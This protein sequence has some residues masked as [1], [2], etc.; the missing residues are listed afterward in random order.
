MTTSINANAVIIIN[1]HHFKASEA[2]MWNLT[3]I[4]KVLKLKRGKSPSEWRTKEAKRFSECP[5]KMRSLGQ[6]VT[7]RILADKQVTL[8]YAGWV[9]PEFEDMVYAAFEAILAI[10][11]V[12][13]VV[14]NKMV[15]LSHKAE[16]E[17][18]ERHTN[19]DRDY[20][21]AQLK[22]LRGSVRSRNWQATKRKLYHPT[23]ASIMKQGSH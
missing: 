15:E 16:A 19:A 5:Q 2:G 6:G 22:K 20:A 1:D 8:K 3:E 18:L 9:S 4:W 13:A 17:F 12:A 14:A 23:A 10:P 7:S 21:H 11:E